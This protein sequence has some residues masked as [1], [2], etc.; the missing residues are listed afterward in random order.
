MKKQLIFLMASL[1]AG[2]IIDTYKA[3]QMLD[4][5]SFSSGILFIFVYVFVD[6]IMMHKILDLDIDICL[7]RFFSPTKSTLDSFACFLPFFMA[8]YFYIKGDISLFSIVII[9][10]TIGDLYYFYKNT[11]KKSDMQ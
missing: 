8:T 2:L 1:S 4:V 10:I 6:I 7:D 3:F 9:S 11:Q 5:D